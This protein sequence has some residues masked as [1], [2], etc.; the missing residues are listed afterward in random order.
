MDAQV[1]DQNLIF[2]IYLNKDRSGAP[3]D[4]VNLTTAEPPRSLG[5]SL[6]KGGRARVQGDHVYSRCAHPRV[7]DARYPGKGCGR[8]GE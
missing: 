3:Q 8:A 7:P 5:T 4:P 6:E 1:E 2:Q